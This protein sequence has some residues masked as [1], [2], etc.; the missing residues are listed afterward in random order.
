[1]PLPLVRTQLSLGST[2]R[3]MNR[4]VSVLLSRMRKM[5]GWS[6]VII[7]GMESVIDTPV[8]AAASVPSSLTETYA[9]C[10]TW[11]MKRSR[12]PS[13]PEKSAAPVKA[14]GIP[15]WARVSPRENSEVSSNLGILNC[16]FSE[17]N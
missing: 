8:A 1:L 4:M 16:T 6:I 13:I 5:N 10:A 14:S 15:S 3:P 17:H 2:T 9:L 12:V 7:E 11:P